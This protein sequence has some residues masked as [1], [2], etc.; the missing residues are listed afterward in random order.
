MRYFR[1]YHTNVYTERP[2]LQPMCSYSG[3]NL[4]SNEDGL[5]TLLHTQEETNENFPGD[6]L[7]QEERLSVSFLNYIGLHIFL[8]WSSS[9]HC[10]SLAALTLVFWGHYVA[11]ISNNRMEQELT[12]TVKKLV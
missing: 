9:W 2:F 5:L 8:L 7:P 10:F 6:L 1:E 3:K 11:F 12:D 4:A